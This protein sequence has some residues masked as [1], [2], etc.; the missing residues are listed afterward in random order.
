MV[1]IQIIC[2]IKQSSSISNHL[3]Y[4]SLFRYKPVF[5]FRVIAA[6]LYLDYL[7]SSIHFLL[8]LDCL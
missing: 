7:I 4:L 8:K 6:I 5:T 2:D 3:L 1:F